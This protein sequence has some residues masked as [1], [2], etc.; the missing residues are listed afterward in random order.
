MFE[1]PEEPCNKSYFSELISSIADVKF[2]HS[3]RYMLT[4]DYLSIKVWDLHMENKPIETYHVHEYLRSKLS[5]L[6]ENDC[7]FDKYECCWS[8]DDRLVTYSINMNTFC[9]ILKKYICCLV[10][11][12]VFL[13]CCSFQLNINWIIQ[14]FLPH[15]QP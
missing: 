15:L 9:F 7:I 10:F 8:G 6:Y 2:S 13:H 5:V 4:R 3:G 14:Q 12:A 11:I 1:E